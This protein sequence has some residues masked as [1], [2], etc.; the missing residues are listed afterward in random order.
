ML[1]NLAFYMT[2]SIKRIKKPMVAPMVAPIVASIKRK[3]VKGKPKVAPEAIQDIIQVKTL[4]TEDTGKQ[5]EMAIC[6]AFNIP[7]NG[8]YKYGME[9]PE[10]LK[11]RLSKLT[12]LF[13]KCIHTAKNGSRYDY[14][15]EDK[16]LSAKSTKK[17]GKVAP[18]VIGQSQPKKFCEI[19]GIEYTT[20]SSLK[21]Y[22]QKNISNILPILVSYTFDCIKWIG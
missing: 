14:T 5:F 21:E 10:I 1:L 11:P 9:L 12:E 4:Q 7:Y 2:D 8:P 17:G 16:H 20:N 22:I 13:P 15:S 19:I 6:L 3:G 18:Q